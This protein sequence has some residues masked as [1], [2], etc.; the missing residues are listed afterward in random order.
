MSA[1]TFNPANWP[2]DMSGCDVWSD[3]R[4]TGVV[5]TRILNAASHAV[6][7][8]GKRRWATG[9]RMIRPTAECGCRAICSHRRCGQVDELDLRHYVS[10]LI[11]VEDVLVGDVAAVRGVD[12][13]VGNSRLY[14]V[15]GGVLDPWPPQDLNRLEDDPDWSWRVVVSWGEKPPALAL[16]AAAD[17]ACNLARR[18]V[19]TACEVPENALSVSREGVTIRLAQGLSA[20]PSVKMLLDAYPARIRTRRLIDPMKFNR[21]GQEVIDNYDPE[22]ES[23]GGWL[24]N[25]DNLWAWFELAEPTSQPLSVRQG[26]DERFEFTFRETVAAEY[27]PIDITGRTYTAPIFDEDGVQ[28]DSFTVAVESAPGGLVSV[29][30]TG[31]Q[32]L[33]LPRGG[34][35]TWHLV[36]TIAAV[37]TILFEGSRLFIVNSH[38][39]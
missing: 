9:Q 27:V 7:S 18:F 11:E 1:P 37:P 36:E 6:W 14:P 2:L 17:V 35:F 22:P 30:F 21:A 3:V 39:S 32:S 26:I 12:Y 23:K 31:A 5:K 38:G 28:V 8:L 24:P 33:A 20:V 13:W 25:A 15:E 34:S 19:G 10:P 4:L 16:I 29:A